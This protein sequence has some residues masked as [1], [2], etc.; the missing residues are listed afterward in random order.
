MSSRLSPGAAG[1][2]GILVFFVLLSDD[3]IPFICGNGDNYFYL[4]DVKIRISPNIKI[5]ILLIHEAYYCNNFLYKLR[6]ERY[7]VNSYGKS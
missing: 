2:F 3:F 7:G 1:G 4:H 6:K 5:H